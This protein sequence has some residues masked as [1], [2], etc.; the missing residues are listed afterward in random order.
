MRVAAVVV[1]AAPGGPSAER[2]IISGAL[3]LGAAGVNV[4]VFSSRPTVGSA[5]PLGAGVALRRLAPRL[6]ERDLARDGAYDV[7][8]AFGLSAMRLVATLRTAPH[9]I[10]TPYGDRWSQPV[11]PHLMQR[12]WP[13]PS[14][15]LAGAVDT[16]VCGSDREANRIRRELPELADRLRVVRPGID[17]EALREAEPVP[18]GRAVVL[19]LGPLIRS[20]RLVRVVGALASL[21]ERF[22]LVVLGDG[23]ARR[24]LRNVVE[25]LGLRDR[26]RFLGDVTP[27]ERRRWMSTA[28][29]LLPI[30][31]YEDVETLALEAASMGKPLI[32]PDSAEYA[33]G[34]E[35]GSA[36]TMRV[37]SGPSSPI[38]IADAIRE[39]AVLHGP[40]PTPQVR[41][42]ADY[43]Q[44][45]LGVYRLTMRGLREL[46][47]P[48]AVEWADE[49]PLSPAPFEQQ[50]RIS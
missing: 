41:S 4:D 29:V 13:R 6:L 5:R 43:A 17:A 14:A 21:D 31:E 38:A 44:E 33:G 27:D 8:H 34:W 35:Y 1:H 30:S 26:V 3:A 20:P 45:M 18:I 49:P 9:R 36:E 40:P 50:G 32:I 15:L 37:I 12:P 28:S 47:P 24:R 11:S 23:P 10:F 7:V 46:E 42:W 25:D 16:I 48:P 39:T 22:V 2:R 19:A